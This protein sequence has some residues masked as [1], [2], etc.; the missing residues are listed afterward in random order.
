MLAMVVCLST[1][2]VWACFK[3][4]YEWRNVAFIGYQLGLVC[5][6][7]YMNVRFRW[8]YAK[9]ALNPLCHGFLLKLNVAD[10]DVLQEALEGALPKSK[11]KGTCYFSVCSQSLTLM[12]G[13]LHGPIWS[14][15]CVLLM[16][17]C[18]CHGRSRTV[19]RRRDGC[20]IRYLPL[21]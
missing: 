2:I 4:C 3:K 20:R 13:Q 9:H 21:F 16:G 8:H 10:V 7:K 18:I 19:A 14:T 17:P 15:T 5:Q 1:F 12:N 11:G 6:D